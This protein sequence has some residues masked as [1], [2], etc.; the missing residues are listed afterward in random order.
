MRKFESNQLPANTP[1][2]DRRSA[3]TCL[4][5]KGMLFGVFDGHGG[6]ACAQAVSE[7]L[8]YYVAVAM[9]PQRGLEELER[10]MEHGRPVPPILQWYK[11]HG[12]YNNRESASLY[13]DHLRVFWQELLDSEE[14]GEGM[15]PQDALNHA[16]RRLDTDISLEAQVPLSNDLMK[17][18][19]IQVA[20]AGCT[21]CVAHVGSEG[22]HVANAGDC[23]VVL[24]VREED[25]SWSALPLSWDHNSQNQAEVERIRALHPAGERDTVVTD[26]RLLGILMPLR[27]FGDVGF[28]WSLELQS[29]VLKGLEAGVD[30]D[31]LNLYHY[32]PPNFLSPPYLDVTPELAYHK[33]RPQDHF[34]ILG[35]DGLWDE[36]GSDEA[37]H[38]VGEHLSGIHLQ[39]PVSPSERKLNLGQMHELLLKRRDR[40][41][42]TMDTNAAT[43]LIR[44]ALGTGEY[45]ELC[46]ERLAAMLALPEDLARMYR[47]DITATVVYLNSDLVKPH[48][49]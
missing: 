8:L 46:H 9:M 42:P 39:A 44:H 29:S 33:L 19:A 43:H 6:W 22:I 11:H 23:R 30:L 41:N 16:F 26:D 27:A 7:R 18:T 1:N 21:A 35:S 34:L 2:E 12:D 32:T 36:L 28:K 31:S 45:G 47:D 25:G 48:H 24:G 4:Q 5:T 15:S 14:H 20:F 13:V 10:C 49:S 37:V 40:A 3:A 38:L 17:S